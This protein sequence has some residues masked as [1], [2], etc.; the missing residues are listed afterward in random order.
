ML[1]A[2][3]KDQGHKVEVISKNKKGLCPK[4]SK[5]FRKIQVVSEKKRKKG[6]RSKIS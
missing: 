2:K 4:P 5:I 3:A 6:L 1:E